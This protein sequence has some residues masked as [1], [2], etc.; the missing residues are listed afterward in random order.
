M[1]LIEDDDVVEALSPDRPDH[2]FCERVCCHAEM[3][4]PPTLVVKDDKHAE[5]AECGSRRDEDVN[6][7]QATRVVPKERPPRL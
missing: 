3:H 5:K 2:P 1:P 7:C 4:D 6:G